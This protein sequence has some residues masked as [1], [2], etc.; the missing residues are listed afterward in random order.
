MISRRN[1]FSILLMMLVIFVMFQFSQIVI[2]QGSE[3][4]INAFAKENQERLS[5][6]NAWQKN[7]ESSVDSVAA[8]GN[9]YAVYFS[10][11]E[12]AELEHILTQWCDYTK[13][14]FIKLDTLENFQLPE[15]QPELILLDGANLDFGINCKWLAELTEHE[16]PIVFCTLPTTYKIKVTTKLRDILGIREVRLEET[17]VEGFHLF[18]GFFLGGEA[19][20]VAETEEEIKRQDMNLTIPWYVTASGT[21]TYMVGVKDETKYKREEF[22]SIIWRNTYNDTMV[23]SVYGDYMSTLAGL[24][25]LDTFAYEMNNYEIYPVVNA[26][27]VLIAN[28]P[29]FSG[30]NSEQLM[31][32]YSRSPQM[33]FQDVM[34]PSISSMSTTGNLKLTCFMNPQYD[35]T[36]GLEPDGELV[37]FYLQQLKQINSEAGLALKYQEGTDF[38]TVLTKDNHF[39]QSLNSSYIYQALYAEKED[40]LHIEENIQATDLLKNV[41][42][43][44]CEFSDGYPLLSYFTNDV[45]LQGTTGNAEK[46]SYM[47]NFIVKGLQTSLG[48]SNVLLDL[49]P[50]I[51]PQNLEDQWQYLYD[52]MSSNVLTYWSKDNGFD[53]TTLSESDERVRSFLNLNYQDTRVDNKIILT[54]SNFGEEAWFILRTHDEKITSIK[55]G[56]YSQLEK[57]AYLVKIFEPTVEIELEGLSLQEQGAK[58]W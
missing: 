42:T 38:K 23:Y 50:A 5:G 39:F 18:E 51:W 34:W 53:K 31:R 12:N 35:Y 26:Q 45:T 48:Y 16:V 49:H 1:Y 55:G 7:E 13:R 47:D 29:G 56:T 20:Y 46:H 15:K 17:E 25:I 37:P 27:N 6:D 40:M 11:A 9:G 22:P 3:F 21:K 33:T 14:N 10:Q 58:T 52:D 8:D 28:F 54:A 32:L 2:D 57:N 4:D 36:D 19:F 43:M 24:G 41:K 44:S 30:E